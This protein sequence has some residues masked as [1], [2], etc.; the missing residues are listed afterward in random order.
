MKHKI[1]P[2]KYDAVTTTKALLA[3]CGDEKWNYTPTKVSYHIPMPMSA[4][5]EFGSI[6]ILDELLG[7]I[8]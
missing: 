4:I 8:K 2:I 6:K 5:K 1:K 7:A 3:I